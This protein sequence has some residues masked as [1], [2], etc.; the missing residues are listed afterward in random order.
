MNDRIV[1]L[2]II[3]I[4]FHR[5]SVYDHSEIHFGASV[6]VCDSAG[7]PSIA[8]MSL[9]F[10]GLLLS[11]NRKMFFVGRRPVGGGGITKF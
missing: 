7:H 11:K 5:L 1:T 3:I 2:L 8:I 9:I 4:V 6:R 10:N